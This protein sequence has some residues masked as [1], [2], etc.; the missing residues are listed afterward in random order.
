MV[1]ERNIEHRGFTR[2]SVPAVSPERLTGSLMLA[3]MAASGTARA[4]AAGF[5][6]GIH[7]LELSGGAPEPVEQAGVAQNRAV[8]LGETLVFHVLRAVRDSSDGSYTLTVVVLG[9]FFEGASAAEVQSSHPFGKAPFDCKVPADFQFFGVL[10]SS[11][12]HVRAFLLADP[13]RVRISREA[14]DLLAS[15]EK[16]MNA[17][18]GGGSSQNSS[19]SSS[20]GDASAGKRS[21]VHIK[22]IFGS[23]VPFKCPCNSSKFVE[24]LL[25]VVPILRLHQLYPAPGLEGWVHPVE[26]P[27]FQAHVSSALR[28]LDALRRLK[29]GAPTALPDP[30]STLFA[31]V[32]H[33]RGHG[34][35]HPLQP[36]NPQLVEIAFKWSFGP[37]SKIFLEAF[38]EPGHTIERVY[39]EART[40]DFNA[41][42]KHFIAVA[43][44]NW[45]HLLSIL[46]PP[47]SKGD[48]WYDHFSRLA[49]LVR[50]GPFLCGSTKRGV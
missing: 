1:P 7:V 14:V 8:A 28:Y 48:L 15:I 30:A 36:L 47:S 20:A 5:D 22:W 32:T 49:S 34:L 21:D 2:F 33:F 29:D 39:A 12:E 42:Q 24:Y 19:S 44:E 25:S 16:V 11:K 10:G 4:H 13:E 18:G 35:L 17:T 6:Q 3:S 50:S 31:Q 46:F 23:D 45:G 27:G 41:Q 43:L 26:N 9:R 38:A 40:A 37:D